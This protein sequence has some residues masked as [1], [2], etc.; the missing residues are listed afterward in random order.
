MKPISVIIKSRRQELGLT[1][2]ELAA[3]VG[4]SEGTISRW[5]S[6]EIKN[7]RRTAVS[8]LAKALALSPAV[9][10][11]WE[12]A[13]DYMMLE[14]YIPLQKKEIPL[15]G[16]IAA[17]EP[18]YAAGKVEEYLPCSEDV[19]A[20]YAL[21]VHGDSMIN[22]GI[23]DG[24]IVYIRAQDDVEDGEIAAVLIDDS[25]T[26]KRVYRHPG[27]AQLV[28]ENPKYAPMIFNDGNCS[29]FRILGKA[30]AVLNRL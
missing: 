28:P 26:L 20:D 29:T 27:Y 5:E 22:A 12:K 13:P 18:I 3:K 10:M 4:V 1:M 16:E 14:D 7:M 23:K 30:I 21:R 9:I 24:D 6:G 11:G 8:N 25:T 17:G 2:K 19:K 15:L